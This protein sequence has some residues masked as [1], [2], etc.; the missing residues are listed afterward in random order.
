MVKIPQPGEALELT[1]FI[2]AD[3]SP[4]PAVSIC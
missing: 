2:D 1:Q 4:K 3:P